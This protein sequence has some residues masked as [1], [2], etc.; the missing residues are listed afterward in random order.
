MKVFLASLSLFHCG[1]CLAVVQ[2]VTEGKR[3]VSVHLELKACF[4]YS[5]EDSSDMYTKRKK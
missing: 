4:T 1:T 2:F 5:V 3:E